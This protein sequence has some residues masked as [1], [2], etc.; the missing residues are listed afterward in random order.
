MGVT[1]AIGIADAASDLL[2]RLVWVLGDDQDV[3]SSRR[4][5]SKLSTEIRHRRRDLDAMWE[6]PPLTTLE[7]NES[8]WML[9]L[10]SY[11]RLMVGWTDDSAA[12]AEAEFDALIEDVRR[13]G[14]APAHARQPSSCA[15]PS[16]NRR[17]APSVRLSATWSTRSSS[18]CLSGS[19]PYQARHVPGRTSSAII[20]SSS[21]TGARSCDRGTR[22]RPARS[23][24][25]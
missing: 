3:A 21:T 10:A 11:E 6:Q 9:R 12:A 13:T 18:S 22:S 17:P 25:T 19:V 2:R 14:R 1:T 23:C 24:C 4:A 8:Y 16:A 15:G 5:V 7:P 20:A